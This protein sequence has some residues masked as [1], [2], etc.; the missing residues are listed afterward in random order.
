MG[1]RHGCAAGGEYG[2]AVE[3]KRMQA[4]K[5]GSIG[6]CNEG[7]SGAGIKD[8]MGWATYSKRCGQIIL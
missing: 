3:K 4:L 5:M 7:A 6:V 8:D 1:R 2:W